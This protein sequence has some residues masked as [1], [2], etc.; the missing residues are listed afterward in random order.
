MLYN[1]QLLWLVFSKKKYQP[2]L[3]NSPGPLMSASKGFT[4]PIAEVTK[5]HIATLSVVKCLHCLAHQLQ[6]IVHFAE[7]ERD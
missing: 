3:A 1:L 7:L 4:S 6:S 5:S 2:P